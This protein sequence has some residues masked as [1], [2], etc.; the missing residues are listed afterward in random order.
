MKNVTYL[1]KNYLAYIVPLV[2][3]E[4]FS[5]VPFFLYTLYITSANYAICANSLYITSVD[6]AIV[7]TNVTDILITM[8]Y[9]AFRK[10]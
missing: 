4:L 7:Q 10:M 6:Y 8:Y 9:Y 1:V 3:H 5:E 2:H